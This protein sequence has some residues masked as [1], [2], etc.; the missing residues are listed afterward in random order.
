[1]IQIY[2]IM[3][4]VIWGNAG[5]MDLFYPGTVI[6]PNS[7]VIMYLI[8]Y[9]IMY[10]ILYIIM[11]Q[12]LYIYIYIYIFIYIYIHIYIYRLS[13]QAMCTW[14]DKYNEYKVQIVKVN[15][16]ALFYF[17]KNLSTYLPLALSYYFI[18][19]WSKEIELL[20]QL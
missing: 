16:P 11:Y 10:P 18:R 9:T 14:A 19:F 12:I 7:R 13:N 4:R 17:L 5:Q 3:A 1:M 20:P 6:T 8:L 15:L 2:P